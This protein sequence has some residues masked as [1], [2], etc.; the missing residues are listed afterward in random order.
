MKDA[1]KFWLSPYNTE[2]DVQA[3]L[4]D[5]PK[6]IK[7]YDTTLRDGEQTVGV[8]MNVE[9]K[10]RIAQALADAGVDRIEA[11]FASS[12]PEDKAAVTKIK[13]SVKNAD[14][15]GFA[16]CNVNDVKDVVETGVRSLVCEILT[17]PE[18]MKAWNNDEETVLKRIR[19]AVSFAKK[20][21][22]YVA[23]FAVDA[24]RA[25]LPFLEKVYKTAVDECGADEVV[26]VDTLGVA[27][28]EAMYWLVK[29]I[30]SWVSVPVAVHCHND[31]GLA[32]ACSL[33][34]IRAGASSAHVCVNGLGEKTGNCDLA[35]LAIA[36]R[37]LY[38]IETN[39]KLDKLRGLS[40]LVEE[41]TRIRVSPQKP[42]VG[43]LAFA[44]ESGLVI[45]QLRSY[46]PSVE[47][48]DPSVVGR[49][50]EI[51]LGKKSGKK[52][53]EYALEQIGAPEE[54]PENINILLAGIKQLSVEKRASIT[55]DD[56]RGL[57]A[58]LKK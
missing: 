6:T 10:V 52:S 57:Y 51:A 39:L 35:E 32:S 30:R 22:L 42:V 43:D 38:G 58:K 45:A 3:Q 5:M 29:K 41:I 31:F 40:K 50:R 1:D 23:Y 11:G 4:K 36:L 18:K 21:G 26:A 20:E 2:A 7:F 49:D 24:T 34:A 55:M 48:Y 16:R 28:P 54:T 14:I 13:A 9:D 37:G 46:P 56:F 33:A 27:S 8:N 17:S 44:R 19:D 47:G 25:R 53:V 12:S 15:W